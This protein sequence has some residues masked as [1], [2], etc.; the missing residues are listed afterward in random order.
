MLSYPAEDR[1]LFPSGSDAYREDG[2][3]LDTLA[4]T[5]DRFS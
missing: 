1:E 5:K 4:A 2:G 3:A